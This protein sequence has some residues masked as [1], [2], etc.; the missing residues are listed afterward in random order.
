MQNITYTRAEALYYM[1]EVLPNFLAI[2]MDYQNFW[3]L[4]AETPVCNN[5]Q[6]PDLWLP[7]DLNRLQDLPRMTL[8]IWGVTIT[9]YKGDWKQS[10]MTIEQATEMMQGTAVKKK[11]T[12]KKNAKKKGETPAPVEEPTKPT[13]RVRTEEER[14]AAAGVRRKTITTPTAL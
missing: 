1:H 13:V 2:G 7:Q 12:K 3:Y 6:Y 8:N 11:A 9:D 14:L 5:S 10:M 4:F